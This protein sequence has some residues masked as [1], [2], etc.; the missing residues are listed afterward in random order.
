[1]MK[2]GGTSDEVQRAL[3]GQDQSISP[4]TTELHQANYV[5]ALLDKG[6]RVTRPTRHGRQAQVWIATWRGKEAIRLGLPIW[7]GK[8]DPTAAKHKGDPQ[9]TAAFR[10][11]NRVR[12][13]R[14]VPAEFVKCTP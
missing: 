7:I 2:L 3:G 1:M 14:Q 6:A 11:S 13:R 12:L 9:S 5:E 4:R 8:G 10:S